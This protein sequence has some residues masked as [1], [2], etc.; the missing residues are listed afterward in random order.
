MSSG[1]S[2][3]QS[4]AGHDIYWPTSRGETHTNEN[5]VLFTVG[6]SEGPTVEEEV[7]SNP[8]CACLLCIFPVFL[9]P[10]G[11]LRR[12]TMAPDGAQI[13]LAPPRV[14]V[15]LSYPTFSSSFFFLVRLLSQISP[16]LSQD[17]QT[18]PLVVGL[19]LRKKRAGQQRLI[20]EYQ[21]AWP[22]VASVSSLS[23]KWPPS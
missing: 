13:G 6:T 19:L 18:R 20:T 16:M 3:K 11:A 5:L 4:T 15:V 8:Q 2:G 10:R 21:F 23:S 22:P 14:L 17:C 7:Y 12:P 9:S 1:L